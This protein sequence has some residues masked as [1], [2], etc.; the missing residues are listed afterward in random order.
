MTA[1]VS[2]F[3]SS[4]TTNTT[5][6]N[7]QLDT[8]VVDASGAAGN[9][10]KAI[11]A[12]R[13]VRLSSITRAHYVKFSDNPAVVASTSDY[14]FYMPAGNTEVFSLPTG[15]NG[16]LP[17]YIAALAVGGAGSLTINQGNGE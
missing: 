10:T 16:N 14:D 12:G 9:P 6:V 3:T 4:L 7:T 2:T 8:G 5:S 11:G 13:Q 1:F 17:K 15:S